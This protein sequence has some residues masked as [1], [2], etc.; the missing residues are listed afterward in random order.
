ML[1]H[2]C[3]SEDGAAEF[4]NRPHA[5][6][7]YRQP[8]ERG[9]LGEGKDKKTANGDMYMR[10]VE[11]T[12][13]WRAEA[14]ARTA[15]KTGSGE[16]DLSRARRDR[17]RSWKHYLNAA[18]QSEKRRSKTGVERKERRRA[19]PLF[20]GT[21]RETQRASR[22][23]NCEDTRPSMGNGGFGDGDSV[24]ADERRRRLRAR[25]GEVGLE[26][27]RVRGCWATGRV[28]SLQRAPKG[29]WRRLSGQRA[30][31]GLQGGASPNPPRHFTKASLK[32]HCKVQNP[33]QSHW[34]AHWSAYWPPLP[35]GLSMYKVLCMYFLLLWAAIS[36]FGRGAS[37][38]LPPPTTTLNANH[39]P[40]QQHHHPAPPPDP[41]RAT[42]RHGPRCLCPPAFDRLIPDRHPC[43]LA[44]HRRCP[45]SPCTAMSRYEYPKEDDEEG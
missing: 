8:R 2:D 24:S 21:I 44:C 42:R 22:V 35:P 41:L 33:L 39:P 16:N 37:L 43:S 32:H 25:W 14:R 5:T 11:S 20:E 29:R 3:R 13:S 31:G 18:Y 40:Q 27:I 34:S 45:A 12:S 7:L 9:M 26:P 23:A 17:C 38:D 30:T 6:I 1:F 19:R 36:I 4:R 10:P 15:A 28:I